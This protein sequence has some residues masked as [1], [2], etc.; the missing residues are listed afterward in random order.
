[1]ALGRRKE[2][3][4]QELFVTTD[5]LSTADGHVFY[6]K[7]NQLLAHEGFGRWVEELCSSYY[8]PSRGRPGIPPSV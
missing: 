8:S 1:M 4:Q 6:S 3:R 2:A 5:L 7:F